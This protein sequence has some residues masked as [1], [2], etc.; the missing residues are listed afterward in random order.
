MKALQDRPGVHVLITNVGIGQSLPRETTVSLVCA[1][2]T[3]NLIITKL[4]K[5]MIV[6][7][8]LCMV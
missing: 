3:R 6:R 4:K 1:N 2:F 5:K 8:F 7:L